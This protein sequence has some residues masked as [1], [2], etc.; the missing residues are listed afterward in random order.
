MSLYVLFK[1]ILG[2]IP[3]LKEK[4]MWIDL[5]PLPSKRHLKYKLGSSFKCV[6]KVF[7]S[8]KLIV[9]EVYYYLIINCDESVV[10][11]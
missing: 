10:E 3:C 11:N 5:V 4:V 1:V 8:N 9:L 2:Q 7:G 6:C